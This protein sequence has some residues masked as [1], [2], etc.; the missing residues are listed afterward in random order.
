MVPFLILTMSN[1][2]IQGRRIRQKKGL[3][4]PPKGTLGSSEL[5]EKGNWFAAEI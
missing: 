1:T 5:E 2:G 4:E 3:M